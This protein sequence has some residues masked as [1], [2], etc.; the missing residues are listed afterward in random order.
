[1]IRTVTRAGIIDENLSLGVRC[2][3]LK[4]VVAR[5]DKIWWSCISTV[6]AKI[7]Q[8]CHKTLCRCDTTHLYSASQFEMM[9]RLATSYCTLLVA[10]PS[11]PVC[12]IQYKKYLALTATKSWECCI[13]SRPSSLVNIPPKFWKTP[14]Y[15]HINEC[16]RMSISKILYNNDSRNVSNVSSLVTCLVVCLRVKQYTL[17]TISKSHLILS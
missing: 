15:I 13:I 17:R 4:W 14:V 10:S 1:M 7:R 2:R 9:G 16:H 3:K 12:T 6:P 11:L 5:V 8:T